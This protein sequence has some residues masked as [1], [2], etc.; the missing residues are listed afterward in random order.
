[1]FIFKCWRGSLDQEKDTGI[2]KKTK[3]SDIV[4][5]EEQGFSSRID[6]VFTFKK[7]FEKSIE[8][9]MESHLLSKISQRTL[10]SESR[11]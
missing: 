3:I 4:L 8:F 7:I 2:E 6:G 5:V 9:S 10:D 11:T 1:M